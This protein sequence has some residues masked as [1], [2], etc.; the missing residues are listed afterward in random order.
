M[1]EKRPETSGESNEKITDH[2]FMIMTT[3]MQGVLALESFGGYDNFATIGGKEYSCA[4]A[5]GY[6]DPQTGKITKFGNPQDVE[7]KMRVGNQFSFKVALDLKREKGNFFKVVE[8]RDT[9]NFFQQR[10]RK[11]IETAINRYNS[12]NRGERF[13]FFFL[14]LF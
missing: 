4:I 2:N 12:L 5:N 8:F 13:R 7:P 14:T 9:H 3:D 10:A 6:A 11:N 1:G